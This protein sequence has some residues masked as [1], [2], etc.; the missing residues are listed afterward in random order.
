MLWSNPEDPGERL[1]PAQVLPSQSNSDFLV[2]KQP[3]TITSPS[4]C[5]PLHTSNPKKAVYNTPYISESQNKANIPLAS[6]GLPPLTPNNV[7]FYSLDQRS[8]LPTSK[9]LAMYILLLL[10]AL[11]FICSSTTSISAA[12]HRLPPLASIGVPV[13][14]RRAVFDYINKHNSCNIYTPVST[15]TYTCSNPS[16]AK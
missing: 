1:P 4:S 10:P 9:I 16:F 15:C 5:S 14:S 12:S 2:V 7:V 6:H 8:T 11:T 3:L 13:L